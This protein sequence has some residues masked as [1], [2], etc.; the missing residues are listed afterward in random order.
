MAKILYVGG[1]KSLTILQLCQFF[2]LVGNEKCRLLFDR[3]YHFNKSWEGEYLIK[4]YPTIR[5]WQKFSML[6][7]VHLL[8]SGN[9]ANSYLHLETRIPGCYFT[10][11]NI[12][13]TAGKK[14]T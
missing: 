14:N 7:G 10:E 6:E 12:L 11:P 4:N 13:T 2:A 1:Y 3:T 8:P 5:F 9:S